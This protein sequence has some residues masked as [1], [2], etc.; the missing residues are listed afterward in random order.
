[1]YFDAFRSYYAF[2]AYN[3]LKKLGTQIETNAKNEDGY[4]VLAAQNE[5]EKAVMLVNYDKE[6]T[7]VRLNTDCKNKLVNVYLLDNAH[8]LEII[9]TYKTVDGIVEF[10]LCGNSVVLVKLS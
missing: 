1:M 6:N 9:S 8:N 5:L 2:L 4:Y 10:E 3:E 7:T